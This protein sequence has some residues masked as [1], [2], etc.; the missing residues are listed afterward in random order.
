[1]TEKIEDILRNGYRTWRKNLVI[2][3]A[4]V[5][6]IVFILLFLLV[7]GLILYFSRDS[8]MGYLGLNI[9]WI[10]P[11]LI[12]WTNV[13]LFVVVFFVILHLVV[14]LIVSYFTAG[15]IGMAK[16]ALEM[17]KT[18]LSDMLFYGKKKFLSLFF[19]MIIIQLIITL[20]SLLLMLPAGIFYYINIL[21]A[22]VAFSVLGV[23]LWFAYAVVLN[24][25]LIPVSYAIV[26]SDLGAFDGLRRGYR[27]FIENKLASLL[28]VIMGMALGWIFGLALN[29][30][31][32]IISI[33][34]M[35]LPFAFVV[36]IP[37]FVIGYL[38]VQ[39]FIVTAIIT[40]W[41]T[42]LYMDRTGMK[43]REIPTEIPVTSVP[44]P[45][46]PTPEP[47]YV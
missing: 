20:G 8:I 44:D 31:F 7:V 6:Q 16:T 42:R 33:V 4:P 37:L 15:A 12:N 47:I 39:A 17:E 2:G 34:G 28:I 10:N 45:E 23:S 27:F 30:V 36:L 32:S 3:V 19:V 29:V 43:P 25:I 38:L 18:S 11:L 14:L 22:A 21:N 9:Y 46:T 24:I 1:M 26:V 13:L 40:V 5:L 35:I 41:W